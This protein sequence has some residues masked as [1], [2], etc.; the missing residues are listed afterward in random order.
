MQRRKV[1]FKLYP[2]AAQSARLEAWTRLH[3]ELYNAALEER[4]D[5]W[6]KAKKSISYYEQQNALP[7]IK[8]DRP[9]FVELGSHALQQTLRR[10]D[11]AFAAFFRRVKAGQTPGF[12]RFKSAKRFSGF[13]YPDPAGWKLM[14]HGGRGATLRLGSG[15][16]ALFIRARGQHRFGS[17]SKPNDLTLTRRNGQWFVSVT[18]RV[19]EEACARQRK[20]DRCR[21]VDFGVTDWAT[22]DDGQIIAN[23]RWLRE[24]LPKLA[25]LQRQRARKRRGS[26]R[27][28]R[29]GQR[30]AR[31]H[32]RIANLRRDFVHQETTRMVQQCAVLATEQLAPKN[33]SRSARSTEQEPGRRVRQK[34]GLNR[35]ILSAAFGMAHQM[36]AYKAEEAGTRLHLSD[37]R[38]LRPSQR[39]AACWEIVPK[40]LADRLHV[41][42][43]CGHV[44]PRDQN[45][46]LVVLIDAN[47]PGTG[48]AARPKPLPRQR[49][50]SK[51]VT[52]ETLATTLCV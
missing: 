45:S 40:T 5:A 52:R 23:P 41:C 4:I 46:A 25:D 19:P 42:P 49:G 15:K 11:L 16:D 51:S 36:L 8:A 22:F 24:E 10:L 38:P 48:V 2:N 21:G 1:T 35:E 34:A 27:H 30:V 18:L 37:T 32:D 13:A 26:V 33:M 44:M 14:G 3:C 20:A 12:P 28:G 9:E 50:K 47:T 31:L 39:C 17:E 6:R 7:A 43:H 29:L